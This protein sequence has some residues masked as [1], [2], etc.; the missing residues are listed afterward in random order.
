MAML[1]SATPMELNW[2]HSRNAASVAFDFEI[3]PAI[4]RASSCQQ[5]TELP[6][7]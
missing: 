5:D 6:V 1:Q 4:K 7:V 3:V 2:H